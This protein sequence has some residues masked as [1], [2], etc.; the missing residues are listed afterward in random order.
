WTH[1]RLYSTKQI[2]AVNGA[3][4]AFVPDC[5]LE[6]VQQ[7]VKGDRADGKRGHQGDA[8]K[9]AEAA[10]RLEIEVAD[11]VVAAAGPQ[12]VG[13]RL[14]RHIR[15]ENAQKERAKGTYDHA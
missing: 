2:G 14:V 15:I 4:C 3:D 12:P 5:R 11:D 8:A 10:V 1:E 7:P 13:T 6:A 9:A